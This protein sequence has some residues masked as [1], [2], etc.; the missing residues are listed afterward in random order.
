MPPAGASGTV[1]VMR[2]KI[3]MIAGLAAATLALLAGRRRCGGGRRPRPH[4]RRRRQ[5]GVP[6]RRP[7][8]TRRWCSPTAR[9]CWP[10]WTPNLDFAVWRLTPDGA[11]DRSFDDDG[12]VAITLG[13][14]DEITA[15][16]LQPDGKIVV[17]GTTHSPPALT[18]PCPARLRHR[19]R[20][21]EPGRRRSTGRSTPRAATAAARRCSAP[22]RTRGPRR[23]PCSRTTARS[24]WPGTRRAATPVLAPAPRLRRCRRD[25]P[26][27]RTRPA[28]RRRVPCRTSSMQPDGAIVV[29]GQARP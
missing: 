24:S 26:C 5:A 9:S 16:A 19:R 29:A 13:G 1:V 10:A 4:V 25:G 20:A 3:T 14:Q 18:A 22:R 17:A 2:P 11:L 12:S 8:R 15:A 27:S 23:W 28:L 7:S 6:V 21:A